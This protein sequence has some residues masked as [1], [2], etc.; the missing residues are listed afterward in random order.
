MLKKYI[1]LIKNETRQKR[2]F[3]KI[4]KSKSTL[5]VTR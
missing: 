5:I 3:S 1:I 2:G 4:E